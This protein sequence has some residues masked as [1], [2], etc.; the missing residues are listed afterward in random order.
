MEQ[1]S[2][3]K[4]RDEIFSNSKLSNNYK[5]RIIA[6]LKENNFGL[7]IADLSKEIGI[8]R[9]TVS[10]VLAELRGA[11]RIEVRRVGVAKLHVLKIEN[12]VK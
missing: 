7:T 2:N 5:E 9:H 1:I 3:Q 12:G 8:T 10:V 6:L 4:K 11:E